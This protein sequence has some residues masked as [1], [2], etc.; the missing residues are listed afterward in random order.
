MKRKKA[1]KIILF[2]SIFLILLT[3][4]SYIV[5]T[6]GNAKNRFAGFYAEPKDSIDVLMFGASPVGTS[7][8][9]GYMWGEYGFTSYPLSTNTQRPKAIRYLLEEAYK[10]QNPEVVVIDVRMFTYE[11]EE[12][13]EDE[14]H[15][16]EVT[17]N[18]RYSLQRI[19]T[20]NALTEKMDNVYTFYF[21]IFKFHSN[22]KMLF[23]PEEL[24]KFA[25]CKKDLHK[26]FEHPETIMKHDTPPLVKTNEQISIPPEQENYLRTLLQYLKEQNQQALFVVTP[27]VDTKEYHEKMNYMENI[28]RSEG[29]QF[30]N[31]NEYYEEM[32]F[33]FSTDLMDGVHTNT[34]GA[35]KASNL[36]GEYLQQNYSLTDRRDAKGYDAWNESYKEFMEIYNKMK[37]VE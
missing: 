33:D 11:D 4:V 17:D 27:S 34:L 14:A 12:M 18:M 2:I 20:I 10:Y 8:S 30:L 3:G 7:F 26:G 21:D 19:K 13:A 35:R 9:A 31:M 1:V 16:R 32:Q 28:V 22:W 5:R 25:Y 15:I 23:L 24:A 37:N 6:N 29:F 36:L